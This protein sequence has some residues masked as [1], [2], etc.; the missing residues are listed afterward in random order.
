M[1]TGTDTGRDT[2]EGR[3]WMPQAWCA[4]FDEREAEV[5]RRIAD[6][7]YDGNRSMALRWLVRRAAG[8]AG[9]AEG[10]A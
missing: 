7:R 1:A 8:A 2:D 10:M 9:A 6:E 3:R 5:I 4:R